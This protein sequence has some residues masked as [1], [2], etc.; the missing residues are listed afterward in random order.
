MAV[1]ADALDV[2][3]R[4]QN[5]RGFQRG[6]AQA[7]AATRNV[8]AASREANMAS[9]SSSRKGLGMMALMRK[10]AGG[11]VLAT[12]AAGFE[13]Y[14]MGVSFDK[15][16]AMVQTNAG[17]SAAEVQLVRKTILNMNDAIADP[18]SLAKAAYFIESVGQRGSQ[19]MDTL[20]A[21]STGAAVGNADV[22]D[23]AQ[24]LAGIMK[25]QIPGAFRDAMGVMSQVN[26]TVGSGAMTLEDYNHAMGTG[27]LP[28]AKKYGLTLTD[29]NGA[30]AVFTDEHITGSSAMAQ[31]ATSFHFLTGATKTGRDALKKIGLG[32][33]SLAADMRKP[34]GLLMALTD[35]QNHLNA[36][37][38][39]PTE[40]NK[41]VQ[42]LLPGGRGRILQV[43]LNQLDNYKSKMDQQER[44]TKNYAHSVAVYHQ[45]A[46][47]KIHHAWNQ[48][49]IDLVKLYDKFK[50]KGTG[51]ILG[52]IA[53]MRILIG[54]LG[55]LATHINGIMGIVVPLAAAF[56]AY[57]GAVLGVYAAQ[58]LLAGLNMVKVFLSLAGAEGVADAAMIAFSGTMLASP[59]M[60]IPLAI[61]AVVLAIVFMIMHWKQVKAVVMDV[62]GWI[63]A[64][65][66]FA[67]FFAILAGPL[68]I[69]VATAI[70]AIK[71]L[72]KHFGWLGNFVKT[73]FHGIVHGIIWAMNLVIK[74]VDFFIRQYNKIPGFLRPTG[75]ITPIH[76]IEDPWG[77]KHMDVSGLPRLTATPH[78]GPTLARS[79]PIF[80]EHSTAP[81][82]SLGQSHDRPTVVEHHSHIHLGKKEV[83]KVVNRFNIDQKARK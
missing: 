77:P 27:V 21:A 32:Q 55:I 48:V 7:S 50:D 70:I 75:K 14:K 4:V 12:A 41:I 2:I 8:G 54:G 49:Q 43:L 45:T 52:L 64:H 13:A 72:H 63:K 23:T 59:I 68:G 31:L 15:Q 66:G 6:M 81:A 79:N 60:W 25:V 78:Q 17:A 24:T 33:D 62:W 80:A 67:L 83:A 29:I 44:T 16:L 74:A 18:T 26:A 51:T 34:R 11:L 61:A 9:E 19:A 58:K 47:Y 30:L 82:G 5:L 65:W 56:V 28:V 42:Q 57:K 40:Q 36:Y 71:L 53:A 1:T 3:L 69:A 20:H 37:S 38:A 73:V 10:A 22:V 39:D 76:P 35:L 46:A